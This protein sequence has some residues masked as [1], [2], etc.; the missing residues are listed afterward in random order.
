M[1]RK[2]IAVK[3]DEYKKNRKLDEWPADEVTP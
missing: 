1:T 3:Y 2:P